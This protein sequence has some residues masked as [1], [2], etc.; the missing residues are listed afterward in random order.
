MRGAVL[1]LSAD[2]TTHAVSSKTMQAFEN[3]ECMQRRDGRREAERRCATVMEPASKP[4]R[5]SW[6]AR[7]MPSDDT[8]ARQ[9]SLR[10]ASDD[11]R[12]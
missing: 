3:G 8:G 1:C 10:A 4:Q 9:V 7:M 12:R 11:V 2:L 5:K 6:R